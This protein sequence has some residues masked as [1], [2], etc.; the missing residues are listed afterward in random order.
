MEIPILSS[1][2]GGMSEVI[3]QECGYLFEK[4]NYNDLINYVLNL[5]KNKSKMRELG[6][7]GRKIENHS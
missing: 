6:K 4:Y 5:I 1:N 2:V 3:N 7:N